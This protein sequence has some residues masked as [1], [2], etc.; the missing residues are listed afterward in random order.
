MK[1]LTIKFACILTF[2]S[3][4]FLGLGQ[5][6]QSEDNFTEVKANLLFGINQPL[7]GGLNVE[8]N[9]FY[10]RWAFDYSHGKSLQMNNEILDDQNQDLGIDVHIPWT[11]GFGIGYRVND[12]LNFRA[13]PK[14]HKFEIYDQGVEQIQKNLLGSYTTFSM[15]VGAYA[16]LQPFKKQ[17]NFLKGIMV[18]PSIRWWPQVSS[19]LGSE[20]LALGGEDRNHEAMEVGIGNTPLII[21]MSIGYSFGWEK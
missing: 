9:L 16:N 5:E 20:E 2:L 13:E 4:N 21:N 15:G 14:W 19:S 17:D 3:I 18:V 1:N 8:G 7:L 10:G 6:I 12:W 11:T